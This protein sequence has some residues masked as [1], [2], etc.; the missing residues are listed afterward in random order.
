MTTAGDPD[1]VGLWHATAA[2]VAYIAAVERPGFTV[3]D[4]TCEALQA[5][6]RLDS[7]EGVA[8]SS[9]DPLRHVLE[10]L[11]AEVAPVGAPGGHSIAAILSAS[12]SNWLEAASLR[13]NN[14]QPFINT[15]P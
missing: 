11:M 2:A 10:G 13:L 14:S 6:R 4:A 1:S 15:Q 7:N 12:L 9:D 3:W 5:W 8:H